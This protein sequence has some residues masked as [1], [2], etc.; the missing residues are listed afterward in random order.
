M[1]EFIY[2]NSTEQESVKKKKKKKK[3][4][5]ESGVEIEGEDYQIMMEQKKL[6]E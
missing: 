5:V 3:K 1:E 2:D 6:E 4:K